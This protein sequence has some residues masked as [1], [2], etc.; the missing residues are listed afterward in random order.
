MKFY[1]QGT[2][3]ISWQLMVKENMNV[4]LSK[5]WKLLRQDMRSLKGWQKI[6]QVFQIKCFWKRKKESV[7]I[8]HHHLKKIKENKPHNNNKSKKKLFSHFQ[9]PIPPFHIPACRNKSDIGFSCQVQSLPSFQA[10]GLACLK[11]FSNFWKMYYKPITEHMI[12][13]IIKPHICVIGLGLC[14]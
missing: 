10:P 4:W 13:W 3:C 7:N 2:A 9:F 12:S 11:V 6:R 8:N 1:P 14:L 5:I